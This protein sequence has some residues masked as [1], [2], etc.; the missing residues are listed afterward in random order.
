MVDM[1]GNRTSTIHRLHQLY[2]PMVRIGPQEISYSNPEVVHE[3][4]SQQT[5]YM[6]APIYETFSLPPIGIFSMRDKAEHSQRRRLL[7]H[8]F[9]QTNLLGTEPLIKDLVKKPIACKDRERVGP[10]WPKRN[11][12]DSN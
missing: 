1:A 8:A 3:I 7:S 4:Y 5:P 9:S 11:H 2:G 6:K 12:N 10:Q